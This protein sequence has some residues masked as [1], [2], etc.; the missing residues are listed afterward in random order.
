ML[1]TARSVGNLGRWAFPS[2]LLSIGR[3]SG[4]WRSAVHAIPFRMQSAQRLSTP[5]TG[6]SALWEAGLDSFIHTGNG[7]EALCPY[8]LKSLHCYKEC[9]FNG[10]S[11]LHYYNDEDGDKDDD[12]DD[13]NGS[14]SEKAAERPGAR[15]PGHCAFLHFQGSIKRRPNPS[16]PCSLLSKVAAT[17]HEALSPDR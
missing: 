3:S 16:K 4:V 1:G 15:T 13:G 9:S 11:M 6:M 14:L 2:L 7:H 12:D 5:P 8:L 10:L 17:Q